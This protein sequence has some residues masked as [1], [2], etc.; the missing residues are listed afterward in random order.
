[1]FPAC[2]EPWVGNQGMSS[3]ITMPIADA[4]T[5]ATTICRMG[6]LRNDHSPSPRSATGHCGAIL[7]LLAD[8]RDADGSAVDADW[9]YD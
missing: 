7:C 1:M 2:R 3:P 6:F 4:I 9:L 5:P 8:G